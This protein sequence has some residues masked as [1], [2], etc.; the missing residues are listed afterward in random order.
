MSYF[1][2]VGDMG[3][4]IFLW[5]CVF[6]GTLWGEWVSSCVKVPVKYKNKVDK[7]PCSGDV[8]KQLTNHN[9]PLKAKLA[10][11]LVMMNGV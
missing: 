9:S 1:C 11:S 3:H 10:S 2:F 4:F 6:R 8:F 5:V 7:I